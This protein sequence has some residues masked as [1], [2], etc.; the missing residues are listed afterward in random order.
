MVRTDHAARS[1]TWWIRAMRADAWPPRFAT[2]EQKEANVAVAMMVD[3]P[4]GSQEVY[5]RIRAHLG[6]EKPAGG[7]FHIAGP[8]PAGG[9]RVLEVWE[10][11]EQANRFFQDRL[12]PALQALGLGGTPPRREFWPVHH[13]M[14]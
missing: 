1:A 3:N 6:L 9:W 7:I 2:S 13:A 12:V 11:E 14:S 8:S 4:E 10:S 5:D